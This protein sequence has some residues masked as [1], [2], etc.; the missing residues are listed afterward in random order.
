MS[1]DAR[2]GSE[3][4][5]EDPGCCV[6]FWMWFASILVLFLLYTTSCCEGTGRSEE[7]AGRRARV[8]CH[9]L[10]PALCG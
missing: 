10:T 8:I 7:D 1:R 5:R 3:D 2:D 4:H 9:A 6:N